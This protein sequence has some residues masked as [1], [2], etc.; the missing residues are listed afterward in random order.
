MYPNPYPSTSAS[1]QLWQSSSDFSPFRSLADLNA[2]TSELLLP[3]QP[4]GLPSG[5]GSS[6]CLS[7]R[8]IPNPVHTVNTTLKNVQ[9]KSRR[10]VSKV[11]FGKA[12][13]TVPPQGHIELTPPPPKY[14]PAPSLDQWATRVGTDEPWPHL[15]YTKPPFSV[16]HSTSKAPDSFSTS[17]SITGPSPHLRVTHIELAHYNDYPVLAEPS[18][19]YTETIDVTLK[20]VFYGKVLAHHFTRKYLNGATT[21]ETLEMNIPPGCLSETLFSFQGAGHQLPGG[22]YQDINFI[23]RVQSHPLYERCGD[24]DLSTEVY[25]PWTDR[26]YEEACQFKLPGVDGDVHT[27]EVDYQLTK[28][29]RGIVIL[30]GHG[31]PRLNRPGRGN[32]I[33]EWEIDG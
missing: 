19:R 23:I 18:T 8:E 27:I 10:F 7:L 2:A 15:P 32:L 17:A 16:N 4:P 21:R 29:T 24:G 11:K 5:Y 13:S 31:M 6:Q 28:M 20:D 3:T 9:A 30:R 12:T 14:A 25:L 1:R 22:E 26:L 33:I